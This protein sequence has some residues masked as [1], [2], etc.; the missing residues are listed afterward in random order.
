[1]YSLI[2]LLLCL[3]CQIA[4]SEALVHGRYPRFN[5]VNNPNVSVSATILQIA[6]SHWEVVNH[7]FNG[8]QM[9]FAIL[10]TGPST[11]PFQ[12]LLR[13]VKEP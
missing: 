5:R 9:A 7:R 12:M 13:A 8:W 10:A 1:M 11:D 4:T 3:I 6:A 2:L